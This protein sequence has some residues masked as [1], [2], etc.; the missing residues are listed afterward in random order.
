MILG[1]KDGKGARVK[2]AAL[3]LGGRILGTWG[4]QH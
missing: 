2:V 3:N 1:K 4:L